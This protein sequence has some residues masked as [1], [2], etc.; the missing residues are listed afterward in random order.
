MVSLVEFKQSPIHGTGGFATKPKIK[1]SRIIEYLG[2]K[3]GRAETLRRC[4][5]NNDYLFYLDENFHLDGNVRWNPARFLNH[6][7]EPNAEAVLEAGQIWI[8]SLRAISI[9]EEITFNYCYDLEDYLDYPCNCGKPGC[10]NFIVAEA[11]FPL[12]RQ[13]ADNRARIT[14]FSSA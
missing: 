9:G 13:R 1:G 12:L 5:A 2:E 8:V 7:C 11:F 4:E 6:S 3:I 10:V 14:G